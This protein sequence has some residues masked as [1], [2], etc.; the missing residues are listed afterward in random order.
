MRQMGRPVAGGARAPGRA[1]AGEVENL[2]A[3]REE[4]GDEDSTSV[5]G[6]IQQRA[7]LER[8]PRGRWSR[9]AP[10]LE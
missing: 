8:A 9:D 7:P 3:E 10:C 4:V 1:V 2:G 5:D 6:E